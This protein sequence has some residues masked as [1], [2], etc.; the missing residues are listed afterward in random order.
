MKAL[1]E[2]QKAHYEALHDSYAAH[3]YDRWSSAYRDEFIYGPMWQG[4]DLNGR[5][6]ADFASGAGHNS[7]ALR[8]RFPGAQVV[9]FDIA[10]T[11]C[12]DYA[13]TL[14]APARQIDLTRPVHAA[15]AEFDAGMIVGGLH[16][17]V[18]DLTAALRNIAILLKPGASFFLVE[19][20]NRHFLERIRRTWY[21]HDSNFD[22]L[23]EQAL[24]HDEVSSQA[25]RWFDVEKVAYFGGPAYFLILNSLI[26]RV[27]PAMKSI[28][29]PP[30]TMAERAWGRLPGKAPHAA[31]VARWRRRETAAE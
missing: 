21:R 13:A 1:S 5:Q 19:P 9:G 27:P 30:L 28:M 16:H 12:R 15:A 31:F 2:R 24:D 7:V 8:Q 11:A 10:E 18:S 20:N 17:C 3:Y 23:T 6:V 25:S 26:L 29:T 14:G 4:V 22:H